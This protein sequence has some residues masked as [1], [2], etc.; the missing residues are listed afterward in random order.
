MPGCPPQQLLHELGRSWMLPLL[1]TLHNDPEM[2]FN[3]LRDELS[4]TNK[5][6]AQRLR[7]LEENG[8]VTKKEY[9]EEAVNRTSYAPTQKALDLQE[10]LDA[11]KKFTTKY[12]ADIPCGDVECT[13]CPYL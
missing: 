3:K 9:Q 7:T 2:G 6:L 10:V 1:N 13:Q 4:I 5:V 11:Y 8:L 12:S